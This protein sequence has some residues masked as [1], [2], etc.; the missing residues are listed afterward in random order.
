MRYTL[1]LLTQ[2]Q[3]QRASSLTCAMEH[4]RRR[5][6]DLGDSEFSIGIWLGGDSTPNRRDEARQVLRKLNQGDDWAENKFVILRCPW[7][8][9][10][11]GPIE[12]ANIRGKSPRGAPRIAGYIEDAGTVVFRCPDSRCEFTTG[13]PVFVID[14]DI[15]DI[16]PSIV[17]AT[18]DKFALLAWNDGCRALFGIGPDG[19]RI[20][21]PPR[22]SFKTSS[23]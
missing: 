16:R 12:K 18:V 3:F 23:I 13:L 6:S 17:I 5:E 2:Q 19:T 4:I 1:R 10:A 7:C 22:P 14:E 11:M 15:Y 20:A 21:S 9:A 8:S